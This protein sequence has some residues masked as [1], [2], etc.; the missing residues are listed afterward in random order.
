[1]VVTLTRIKDVHSAL[2]GSIDA[3]DQ[4]S[5]FKGLSEQAR[6]PCGS[7][8]GL[9][10]PVGARSDQHDG[11]CRALGG[12]VV[13]QVQPAH[14]GHMNVRDDAIKGFI[15]DPADIVLRRSVPVHCKPERR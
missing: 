3:L 11:G 1:M 12:E 7:G 8:L 9:Q 15:P 13:R 6:N 4:V 2:D 5:Y 14:A 10:G